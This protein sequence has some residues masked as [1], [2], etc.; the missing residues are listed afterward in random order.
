MQVHSFSDTHIDPDFL[1][2]K[3]MKVYSHNNYS[4]FVKVS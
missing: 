1:S 2:R 3:L 4:K